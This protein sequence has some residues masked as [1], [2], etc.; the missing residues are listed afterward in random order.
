MAKVAK[1]KKELIR[2]TIH[3]PNR[4]PFTTFESHQSNFSLAVRIALLYYLRTHDPRQD[5]SEFLED[6]INQLVCDEVEKQSVKDAPAEAKDEVMAKTEASH[7]QP[8]PKA[9]SATTVATAPPQASI[10]IP[11]GYL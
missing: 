2:K 4:P 3:L 11:E 6:S 7:P 9:V 5:V 1:P 10:A 8:T